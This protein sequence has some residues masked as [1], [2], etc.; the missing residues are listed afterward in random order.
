MRDLL[1]DAETLYTRDQ[2]HDAF[3][4]AFGFPAGYGRNLDALYDLLTALPRTRLTLR[5][6]EMLVINLGNYGDLTLRVL[7]GAAAENPGFILITE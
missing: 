3:A 6:A 1:L 2:L 5:H 7:A 4:G